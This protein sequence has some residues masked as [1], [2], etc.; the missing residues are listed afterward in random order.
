M[1]CIRCIAMPKI[2]CGLDKMNWSEISAL[3]Y[4]VFNS[5][6]IK[7]Y[8]SVRKPKLI[9]CRPP[10]NTQMKASKRYLEL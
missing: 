3:L 5:S 9:K 8:V 10:H 1:Q 6:G 7:I 2:A 4:N